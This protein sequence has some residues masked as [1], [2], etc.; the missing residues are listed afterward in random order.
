MLKVE[1]KFSDPKHVL[2]RVSGEHNHVVG[3]HNDV[4]TLPL[5]NDPN[6]E[7]IGEEGRRGVK[8]VRTLSTSWALMFQD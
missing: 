3:G 1:Y 7:R 4:G 6:H 2:L 5:S 8:Y